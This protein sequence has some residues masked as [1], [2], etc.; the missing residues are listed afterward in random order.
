MRLFRRREIPSERTR[1]MLMGRDRVMSGDL[2]W[3]EMQREIEKLIELRDRNKGILNL[4]RMEGW[5]EIEEELSFRALSKLKDL[6]DLVLKGES[7][8]AVINAS[9]IRFANELLGL[10]NEPLLESARCTD[11]INSVLT[12]QRNYEEEKRARESGG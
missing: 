1:K 5:Q 11:L 10:V 2:M 12:M 8:K 6:P 3:E 7:E 4:S 9:Y